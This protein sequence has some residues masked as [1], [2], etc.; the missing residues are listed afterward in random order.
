LYQFTRCCIA[1][2]FPENFDLDINTA[3]ALLANTTKPAAMAFTLTRHFALF[4]TIFDIA[5]DAEGTFT[6]KPFLK[7]LIIPTITPMRYGNKAVDVVSEC[8]A[9]NIP[10][11]RILA[12]RQRQP[13]RQHW[14]IF[15][16][17]HRLK[18]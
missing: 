2:D 4:V 9:H 16:R 8:I 1:T 17:S 18:S 3:Y 5:A 12:G 11:S 7:P 14:R 15:L 10:I 6:K 13:P